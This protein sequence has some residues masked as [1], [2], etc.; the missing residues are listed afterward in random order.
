ML[1]GAG[2]RPYNGVPLGT[3]HAP[4]L[5]KR[6]RTHPK[7]NEA[8]A[9]GRNLYRGSKQNGSIR[10]GPSISLGFTLDF[11]VPSGMR[12]RQSSFFQVS[13]PSNQTP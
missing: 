3:G 12:E 11:I 6:R 10:I 4:E 7:P 9:G 1:S 5:D 8:G 13:V 2:C